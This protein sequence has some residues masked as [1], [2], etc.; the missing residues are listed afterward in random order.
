MR[1]AFDFDLG[2]LSDLFNRGFEGYFVPVAESAEGL[3]ARLC[4]D[5]IDLSLSR[6]AFLDDRAVGVIYVSVRGWGCRIAGMG[7]IADARR[8]GVGRRLMTAAIARTR[9]SGFRSMT[10]EVIE[11]NTPA[12]ALYRGLGFRSSRRL[13]GYEHSGVAAVLDGEGRRDAGALES[14][15]S[16]KIAHRVTR[17]VE[18]ELPWQLAAETLA[19]YGPWVR[20]VHLAGR[21]FALIQDPGDGAVV[22]HTL[23]VPRE[24]RQAGWGRRLVRALFTLY[25]GRPFRIPARVP[26]D[27][28]AD[29]LSELGFER[30]ELT[31]FEMRLDL[32]PAQGLDS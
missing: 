28:A 20:G 30:A 5:S 9:A 8:R 16:R 1:P 27:L 14:A 3:A 21:A 29:F 32:E 10:L 25:E 23:L 6:V 17:E 19:H 18:G 24:H 22:L 26:E 11:Q 4:Y 2:F 13:V 12:V 31:Q 15:D 7:V